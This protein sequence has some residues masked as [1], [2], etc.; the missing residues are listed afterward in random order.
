MFI[1]CKVIENQCSKREPRD[2]VA[3]EQRFRPLD[4]EED[5]NGVQTKK[6]K[7]NQKHSKTLA[8]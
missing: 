1:T 2:E 5:N 3:K 7:N 8:R 6:E 4:D